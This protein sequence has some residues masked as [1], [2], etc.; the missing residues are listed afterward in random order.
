MSEMGTGGTIKATKDGTMTRALTVADYEARIWI[1]R[2]QAVGGY[3]GI[4]RTLN[5]A[6]AAGVV[7]HGEWEA[8]VERTTGLSIRQAQRCMRAAQEIREG[9][10]LGQLDISKATMLLASGLDEEER[11]ILGARAA[12][13]GATVKELREEIRQMKLAKVHDSGALAEAKG[14]LKKAREERD[15]IRAQMQALHKGFEERAD[16]IR[17]AAYIQGKDDGAKEGGRAEAEA[18][19]RIREMEAKLERADVQAKDREKKLG[20]QVK[21]AELRVKDAERKLREAVDAAEERAR[22]AE[23]A[24]REMK[25]TREAIRKEADADARK[26]YEGKLRF[27]AREKEGLDEVLQDMRAELEEKDKAQSAR[28][29]E[30]YKAGQDQARTAAEWK[31]SE[32]IAEAERAR[33]DAEMRA[34]EAEQARID[35]EAELNKQTKYAEALAKKMDEMGERHQMDLACCDREAREEEREK[36]AAEAQEIE[37]LRAELEAAEGREAK[38]AKELAELRKEKAQAGMDAA[39][40][41]RAERMQGMDLAAAV[42]SFIGAAGTLPQMG[43]ALAG[44]EESEREMIRAQVDTVAE[45]VRASRTALEAITADGCIA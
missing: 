45:W 17:K 29:D 3:I 41:I 4:G 33:A 19:G 26:E 38:R 11:E 39:R 28:W 13:D 10:F 42:R 25:E 18:Q 36:I 7:G 27:L 6:K 1:Y 35:A 31:A 12:E 43:P 5:E 21:E 20:D 34:R 22:E 37:Q 44:M 23:K 2:E 15:Q 30:G 40:G 24:A 14:E 9:S 16:E 8:W 32:R